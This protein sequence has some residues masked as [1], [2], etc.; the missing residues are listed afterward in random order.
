MAFQNFLNDYFLILLLSLL[1]GMML[2]ALHTYIWE[3]SSLQ[4]LSS[5]MGTIEGWTFS[6]LC[7]DVQSFRF[8][9]RVEFRLLGHSRTFTESSLNWCLGCVLRITILLE[10]KHAAKSEVLR[11]LDQV[12]TKC[13]AP[14]II[15]STF[16]CLHVPAPSFALELSPISKQELNLSD[17]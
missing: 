14:F 4:I 16:T 9:S 10:S 2:D 17:H 13:S 3:C 5:W 11:A 12:F 1:W 6:G 7:R 15:P 8:R